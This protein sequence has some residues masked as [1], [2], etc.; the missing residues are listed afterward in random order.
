MS[1]VAISKKDMRSNDQNW[2]DSQDQTAA[3]SWRTAQIEL[4]GLNKINHCFSTVCSTEVKITAE[5]W[6]EVPYAGL[7]F[8]Q[9]ENVVTKKYIYE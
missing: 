8:E 5:D 2:M 7:V 4:L 3:C 6:V 1:Y 9:N